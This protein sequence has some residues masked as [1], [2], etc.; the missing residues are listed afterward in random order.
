MSN[1]NLA[2]ECLRLISRIARRGASSTDPA[3]IGYVLEEL[4]QV[5]FERSGTEHRAFEPIPADQIGGLQKLREEL[6]WVD[7]FGQ[8]HARII[9]R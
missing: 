4:S 3:L 7:R 1:V 9:R 2:R 5:L 8:D 6:E